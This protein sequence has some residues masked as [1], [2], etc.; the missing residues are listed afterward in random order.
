MKTKN[1]L[2][3]ALIAP[4]M[5]AAFLFTATLGAT[6]TFAQGLPI[7][8]SIPSPLP[9]NVPSIA[10]ES[11]SV[12]EFGDRVQFSAGSGRNL[13]TVEQ[14]MSS[15]ACESGFYANNNCVTTPGATFSHPI[16]LNIYN[17]GAT[18]A[19]GS[20]IKTVTQTFAIPYRPSADNANC[21]GSNAGKWFD[22]TACRNGLATPI[23]FNVGGLIVPDEV[24][25]GI[26]FNT[27]SFGYQPIGAKP[28][29]ATEAGCGY[30]SLN[31]GLGGT[32]PPLV[33]VNPDPT[34]VYWNTKIA[35]NY[36]D[37]GTGGV[38]IFRRDGSCWTGFQP[39]VKFNATNA[40]TNADQCKNGGWMTLTRSDG[41]LFKNQGD[42]VSFTKN[43]R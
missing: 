4:L 43:G 32:T 2:A 19:V 27:T 11:Q 16:T 18:G 42:C 21:T 1:I 24:I 10:F 33:G 28:C 34:D 38:G 8:N 23:T 6:Q 26:A 40:P 7:Y 29:S 20:L 22:G 36:C 39:A 14:I 25:Y 12:S 30:D 41:T 37:G 13:V 35:G 15:W 17:V 31:V 5:A 9:G 3:A